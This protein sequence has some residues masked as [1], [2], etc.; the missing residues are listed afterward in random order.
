MNLRVEPGKAVGLALM[1]AH[2][3]DEALDAVL[4][5][6]RRP[7]TDA[8]IGLDNPGDV[9]RLRLF[10]TI[11]DLVVLSGLLLTDQANALG[12]TPDE[13]AAMIIDGPGDE[14]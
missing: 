9:E 1:S 5:V 4:D 8:G 2:D 13:L 10:L 7:L 3:D 6:L 14:D 12:K 11:S